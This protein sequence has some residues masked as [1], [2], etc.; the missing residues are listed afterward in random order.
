MGVYFKIYSYFKN[1]SQEFR[2]RNINETID[3]FPEEVEKHK[4]MNKKHK[5]VCTTLSYI[6]HI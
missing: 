4:L 1:M 5:K 2:L 3:Y 6:E